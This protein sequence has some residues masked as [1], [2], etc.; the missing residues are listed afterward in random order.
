MKDSDVT[1]EQIS[2][3]LRAK[4]AQYGYNNIESVML[5]IAQ[6]WLGSLFRGDGKYARQAIREAIV[7][8]LGNKTQKRK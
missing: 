3:A 4:A 5:G 1:D 7:N 8:P 2:R 6:A